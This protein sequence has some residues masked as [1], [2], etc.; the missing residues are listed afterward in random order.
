M[1]RCRRRGQSR[2]PGTGQMRRRSEQQTVFFMGIPPFHGKW[3]GMAVQCIGK[4]DSDALTIAG[5][6]EE[7]AFSWVCS[8]WQIQQLREGAK[9]TKKTVPA[10]PHTDV[11]QGQDKSFGFCDLR[12]HPCLLRFGR[13]PFAENQHSPCPITEASVTGYSACGLSPCPR[14]T[15]YLL[16]SRPPF[17][18]TGT[19]CTCA[20]SFTF[21]SLV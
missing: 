8:F 19:L 11:V 1:P 21:A 14:R 20:C 18:A 16:R 6:E 2:R 5:R 15:I 7:D 3:F 4:R 12:C 17:P 13:S 10:Q 9:R